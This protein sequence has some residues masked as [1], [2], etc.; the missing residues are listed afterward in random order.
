MP[1]GSPSKGTAS[2]SQPAPMTRRT[3][4]RENKCRIIYFDDAAFAPNNVE[5]QKRE[6][7]DRID[8]DS[9]VTQHTINPCRCYLTGKKTCLE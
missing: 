9:Y 5:D 8:Q 6:I 7:A 4:S 2:F 3:R 1:A